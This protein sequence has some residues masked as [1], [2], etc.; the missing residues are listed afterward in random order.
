[1]AGARA[2][3]TVDLLFGERVA[4]MQAVGGYR[5]SVDSLA[6]AW[7]ADRLCPNRA[8]SVVD[9]GAGTGLVALLLALAL[10]QSR[11]VLVD[12]Q[13]PALERASR[14]LARNGV[15]G[16]CR[17]LLHDCAQPV[18]LALPVDLA[19][20]NPPFHDPAGRQ[21]PANPERRLAHYWT[22][23]TAAD[24]VARVAEL[25]GSHGVGALIVPLAGAE[26]VAHA[27]AQVGLQAQACDVF[28][29]QGRREPIRR[30]VRLGRDADVT[31]PTSVCLHPADG[32][33]SVYSFEIA[34][35]IDRLGPAGQARAQRP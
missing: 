30:L 20:C 27:A 7:F 9:L 28:H 19:M 5:T 32:D 12:F 3:E 31:V 15:A 35:F 34:S 26:L 23:A 16:R 21:L 13:A 18:P 17:T 22:T 29:R 6:L 24:F 14:N 1:M 4:L 25:I 33:D 10:P 11:V 8:P 2:G